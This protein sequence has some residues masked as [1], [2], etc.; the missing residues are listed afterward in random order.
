MIPFVFVSILTLEY[1]FFM[2]EKGNQGTVYQKSIICLYV[3]PQ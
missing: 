3:S 1:S 2:L